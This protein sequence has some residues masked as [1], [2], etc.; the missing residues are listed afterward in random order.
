[1]TDLTSAVTN[2]IVWA[3]NLLTNTFNLTLPFL[4]LL[5]VIL[6]IFQNNHMGCKI[7]PLHTRILSGVIKAPIHTF[8][9]TF[10]SL[11]DSGRVVASL[12]T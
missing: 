9:N 6:P 4:A 2:Y 7:A 10:L 1:M 5:T 3:F 11:Q 8:I 12:A